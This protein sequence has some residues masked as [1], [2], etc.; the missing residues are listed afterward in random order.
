MKHT[1]RILSIITTLAMVGAGGLF[2]EAKHDH[3]A[4]KAPHNG[5][6]METEKVGSMHVEFRVESDK[7][8]NVY[9]YDGKL[10][11]IAP[12]DQA[13]SLTV[14]G[15]DDAKNKVDLVKREDRFTSSS[16][17]AIPDGAKAVLTIKA[18]GKTENLRF[19]LDLSPCNGCKSPEYAC[20]CEH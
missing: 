9:L 20:S 16:P 11:P 12:S 3:A 10:K 4:E 19:G 1:K 13:V 14:Q 17:I 6:L 5:R 8:V 18:G 7:T 2:A 15:K